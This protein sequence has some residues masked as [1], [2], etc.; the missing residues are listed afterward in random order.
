MR[1][2][3]GAATLLALAVAAS[4]SAQGKPEIVLDKVCFD[5]VALGT[6][7]A[8][9]A[10]VKEPS[11]HS[12]SLVL[13]SILRRL[14]ADSLTIAVRDSSEHAVTLEARPQPVGLVCRSQLPQRASPQLAFRVS[15]KGDAQASLLEGHVTGRASGTGDEKSPHLLLA[16]CYV[17]LLIAAT[18]SVQ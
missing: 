1:R 15:L 18:D 2:Q 8:C 14:A 3:F 16:L 17:G 10:V 9:L 4:S 13:A 7:R 11:G 12:F 5:S 6:T